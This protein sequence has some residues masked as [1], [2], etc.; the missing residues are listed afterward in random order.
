MQDPYQLQACGFRSDSPAHAR[1]T[2]LQMLVDEGTT[3]PLP[4]RVNGQVSVR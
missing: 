2:E 4:A 3:V 1:S